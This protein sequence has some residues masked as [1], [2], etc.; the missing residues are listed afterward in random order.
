MQ[1]IPCGWV[2]KDAI[3]VIG[4]GAIV[5]VNLLM[6]EIQMIEEVDPNIR[7]RLIIDDQAGIML[8]EFV[9]EEGHTEGELHQRIGSTGEGVG[10]A[11]IARIRRD[12]SRFQF[13]GY[14]KHE[15]GIAD[16]CMDTV[17]AINGLYTLGRHILL[18]GTQGCGLSLIHGPWPYCTSADTNAAQLAADVGVSPRLVDRVLLVAR[19]YPIRV[20]GNSGPLKDEIDWL[21]VSKRM[22]RKVEERT[23]VTNKVRRIGRWDEDLM[24]MAY[25]I[26]QPTSIAITFMDYL[27]P[28]DEGKNQFEDL[29]NAGQR[30]I[31]YIESNYAP[32]SIIKTGES[33]DATIIRRNV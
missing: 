7:K 24:N 30:F 22:G 1:I 8:N 19:T 16:M 4:R 9:A 31:N 32:V 11:R 10:A 14:V 27:N 28:E 5:N 25:T 26:N 12:P 6:K 17:K 29:S 21:Q 23:T 3:L 2:N 15:L 33:N 18:E 13:I 20:A